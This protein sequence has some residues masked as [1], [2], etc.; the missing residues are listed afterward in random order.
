LDASA[1]EVLK[2]MGVVQKG[3]SRL[4]IDDHGWW[5]VNVNFQPS[6]FSKGSYL[7]VGVQWLWQM[8]AAHAFMVGNRVETFVSYESAEQFKPEADRLATRAAQSV[9]RFRE[10]FPSVEAVSTYYIEQARGGLGP[11]RRRSASAVL[12]QLPPADRYHG[13][14]ALGLVGDAEQAASWFES[15]SSIDDDRPWVATQKDEARRLT[16][17]LADPPRFQAA[18]IATVV[19]TRL[20]LHLP[21]AAESELAGLRR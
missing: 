15:F 12:E 11:L 18:V 6:G 14:V 5:L 10:L 21:E 17:L 19:A 8:F 1:R 7:N 13:A 16:S 3:R 2:P 4:W 9:Q 20:A